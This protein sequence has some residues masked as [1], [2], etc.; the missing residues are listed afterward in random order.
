MIGEGNVNGS[1]I[2]KVVLSGNGLVTLS[3]LL[4]GQKMPDPSIE[5]IRQEGSYLKITG[6][7]AE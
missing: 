1:C 5:S 7:E 3:M 6:T 2:Q 4:I